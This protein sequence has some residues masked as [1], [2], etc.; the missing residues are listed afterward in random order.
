MV[1]GG[2]GEGGVLLKALITTVIPEG[3]EARG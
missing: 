1:Q 2:R 3:S